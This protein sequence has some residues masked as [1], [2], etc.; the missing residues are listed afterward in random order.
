MAGGTAEL[1]VSAVES[2][3]GLRVVIKAPE[4]PAIGVV[5]EPATR[6]EAFA[7]LVV[8]AVTIHARS[9]SILIGGRHMTFLARDDRVQADQGKRRQIVVE[10]YF[11]AP[12]CL[13]VALVTAFSFLSLVDVV[14]LVAAVAI[15]L[16]FFSLD[17]CRVATA[18][19][20]LFVAVTQRKFSILVMIILI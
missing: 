7:V 8:T 4:V 13:V 17:S 2:E 18:T 11:R 10:E 1:G 5:A 3:V 12:R 19:G 20:Q 9:G 6:A 15:R 16:Q 14:I